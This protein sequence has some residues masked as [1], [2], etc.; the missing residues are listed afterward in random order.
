MTTPRRVIVAFDEHSLEPL[1]TCLHHGG[2]CS[3]CG[4]QEQTTRCIRGLLC[5]RPLALKCGG[6]FLP[7]ERLTA[8]HEGIQQACGEMFQTP[9]TPSVR[10]GFAPRAG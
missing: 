5:H 3:C 4:E 1:G 8:S 2:A 10:I 7:G 6:L 9:R